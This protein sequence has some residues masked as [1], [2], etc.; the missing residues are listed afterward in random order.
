[1]LMRSYNLKIPASLY[2]M[3]LTDKVKMS[4][5]FKKRFYGKGKNDLGRK[6]MVG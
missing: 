3:V 2:H 5:F 1:M 6:D 4:L